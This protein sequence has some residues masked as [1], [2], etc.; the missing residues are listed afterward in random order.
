MGRPM[1]FHAP[2][3]L[4]SETP[5]LQPTCPTTPFCQDGHGK[6]RQ[7]PAASH[8]S[9]GMKNPGSGKDPEGEPRRLPTHFRLLQRSNRAPVPTPYLSSSA[10]RCNSTGWEGNGAETGGNRGGRGMGAIGGNGRGKGMG[11]GGGGG[12][13]WGGGI[14]WGAGRRPF[15]PH[16][17]PYPP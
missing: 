14:G 10:N 2:R 7:G 17:P 6:A 15:Q 9:T 5:V 8:H 11:A 1:P 3:V 4:A 12:N 16:S 13:G